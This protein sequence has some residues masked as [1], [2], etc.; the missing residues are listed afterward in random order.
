MRLQNQKLKIWQIKQKARGK[1]CMMFSQRVF[2]KK[3]QCT[4]KSQTDHTVGHYC[5]K[6]LPF[7]IKKGISK[8]N[9]IELS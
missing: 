7:K 9:S 2:P 8:F 5:L 6:V 3:L 4:A 1:P